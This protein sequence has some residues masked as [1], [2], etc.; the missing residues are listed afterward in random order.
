MR[1]RRFIAV[2]MGGP[3][4][5]ERHKSLMIWA[6]K[7]AGRVVDNYGNLN[8]SRPGEALKTGIA[9]AEGKAGAGEAMKASARAHAAARERGSRAAGHAAATAHMADHSHGAGDYALKVLKALGMDIE[10]ER[11]WQDSQLTPD[12]SEPVMSARRLRNKNTVILC[13]KNGNE[14]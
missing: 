8:D 1:D 6:C 10:Q 2:H 12:I 14:F 9:L 7:C 3:L 4:S 11:L 5:P 13:K